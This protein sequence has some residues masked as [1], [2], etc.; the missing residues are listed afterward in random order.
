MLPLILEARPEAFLPYRT[1]FVQDTANNALIQIRIEIIHQSGPHIIRNSKLQ[2]KEAS[3]LLIT[4]MS[5]AHNDFN[6][7]FPCVLIS[8]RQRI[9]ATAHKHL[10]RKVIRIQLLP[11]LS[12]RSLRQAHINITDSSTLYFSITIASRLLDRGRLRIHSSILPISTK[13]PDQY[14]AITVNTGLL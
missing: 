12:S 2:D 6:D 3:P 10:Q 13:H 7:P 14:D 5:A 9:A 1:P 4:T 8:A 11:V